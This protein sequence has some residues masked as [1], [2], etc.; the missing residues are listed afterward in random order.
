MIPFNLHL[1]LADL[2]P[3]AMGEGRAKGFRSR[4]LNRLSKSFKKMGTGEQTPSIPWYTKPALPFSFIPNNLNVL[5][6][7]LREQIFIPCLEWNGK[8]PALLVAARSNWLLHGEVMD[9]FRRLQNTFFFHR[10]NNWSTGDMSFR[11]TNSIRKLKLVG[12]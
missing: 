10:A 1:H 2:R 5:P 11:T 8:T 12:E 7:E 4:L 6:P 3:P 9:I